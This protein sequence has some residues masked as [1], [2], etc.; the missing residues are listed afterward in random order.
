MGHTVGREGCLVKTS[1]GPQPKKQ[2]LY[3]RWDQRDCWYV[4]V[5]RDLGPSW[6]GR[7]RRAATAV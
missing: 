5:F 3:E 7:E 4:D 1:R 6:K 2:V